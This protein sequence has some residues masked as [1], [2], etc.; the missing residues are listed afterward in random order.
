MPRL[1]L[2]IGLAVLVLLAG[3]GPE[4]ATTLRFAVPTAPVTLD[5]RYAT[6][7]AS[8]RV[9]RLLYRALVDFDEAFRVVPDL[10]RWERLEPTRY[11][12]SLGQEGRRFHDGTRLTAVD[13]KVTYDSVLDPDGTSP[14]RGSLGMVE[15]IR[16]VDPDQV[17]FLLKRPDPL[18][19]GRLVVGIAPA[20]RVAAGAALGK[21]P[22]GSGPFA[23]VAWPEEGRLVLRRVADDRRVELSAVQDPTV[24]VLK[25]L[26][27]EADLIQGDLPPEMVAW[28]DGRDELVVQRARGSNFTYLGFNLEDPLTGQ[29]RLRAAVAHG[30][31]RQAIIRYVLGNAARPA[32]ALLLPEHWAGH[33]G[34]VPYYHDPATARELLDQVRRPPG[35]RLAISYKTSSQPLRVRLATVIQHQL[36]EVGL[37][38]DVRSYDWG[39]FYGDIKAGRFQ[40][41]SLSWVGIKM[42]DIFRY[43]FHGGSLPPAGANRGRY[44]SARVDDLVDR[45]EAAT[46]LAEQ[47]RLYRALQEVLHRELPYVPLWYEDHVALHRPRVRGYRVPP[48]GNYDGLAEAQWGRGG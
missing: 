16:V 45:A 17:D 26:R 22:V 24:R 3:C 44:R 23:L 32:T 5:P 27:G 7:A 38:V 4:D 39:T 18:F 28:L 41:F 21:E 15:A 35:Q 30:L 40:M 33:P 10:A 36:A 12:F 48:D 20:A 13:V 31:D 2:A 29:R 47:A 43:V 1:P 46:E 11:R 6:D 9:T 25:L 8:T 34:L 37:A 42:P 19:P 14:H